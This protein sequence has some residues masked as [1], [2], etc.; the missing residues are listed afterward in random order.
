[1]IVSLAGAQEGRGYFFG[2]Y[3]NSSMRAW[4]LKYFG[5]ITNLF[6][7][8]GPTAKILFKLPYFTKRLPWL[9]AARTA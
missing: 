2:K 1:M 4:Q 6:K 3:M 9:A 7:C 8:A 5:F